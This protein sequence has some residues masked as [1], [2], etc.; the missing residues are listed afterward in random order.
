[1]QKALTVK[2]YSFRMLRLCQKSSKSCHGRP[3]V[4]ISAFGIVK[5]LKQHKHL[6]FDDKKA[7]E[8]NKDTHENISR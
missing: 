8:N 6:S 3:L 5:V 1:M 7:Y 2:N 4:K